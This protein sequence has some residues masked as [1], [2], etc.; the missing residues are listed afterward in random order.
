MVQ[1][2]QVLPSQEP[3]YHH[4]QVISFYFFL[5]QYRLL[6][7]QGPSSIAAKIYMSNQHLTIPETQDDLSYALQK[8]L[9][10]TTVSE[11]DKKKCSD[12]FTKVTGII[13]R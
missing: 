6:E 3:A 11:Q 12:D 2:L 1:S 5:G 10:S 8:V 13:K 7:K 4:E 9:R